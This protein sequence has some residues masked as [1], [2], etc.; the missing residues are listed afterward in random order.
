MRSVSGVVKAMWQLICGCTIFFVR[1]LKGV[2][3]ASPAC[4]VKASQRMVRPSSRAASRFS[5]CTSAVPAPGAPRPAEQRPARRC[6]LPDSSRPDVDQPI[7][8]C[9]SGNDGGPGQQLAPSRSFTPGPAALAAYPLHFARPYGTGEIRRNHR[10]RFHL[11]YFRVLPPETR[12]FQQQPHHFGL[13]D[14]QP[15]LAFQHLAHPY[16]IELFVALR[17]R[18]PHRRPRELFSSRN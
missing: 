12:I 17:P 3:S 1:K 15:R 16:A 8:K 10:P 4:S 2:G 6:A 18:T 7:Q 13:P 11:G 9:A 5:A 14:M